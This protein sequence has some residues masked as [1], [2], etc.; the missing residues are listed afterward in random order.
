MDRGSTVADPNKI[1]AQGDE[2]SLGARQLNMWTRGAQ[3]ALQAF[4]GGGSDPLASAPLFTPMRIRNFTEYQI[5]R[6]GVVSYKTPTV[7]PED[8]EHR[9]IHQLTID[10]ILPEDPL[11]R[12]A[13]CLEPI[14]EQGI[15]LAAIFGVVPCWITGTG[16]K[17]E[18]IGGDFQ[19]L[20]AGDSGHPLLWQEDGYGERFALILLGGGSSSSSACGTPRYSLILWYCYGG[21]LKLSLIGVFEPIEISWNSTAE[22]AEDVINAAIGGGATVT[23]GPLPLA[24]LLIEL[25]VHQRLIVIPT[26]ADELTGTDWTPDPTFTLIACGWVI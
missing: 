6:L 14:A 12:F 22:E 21:V 20:Q 16:E 23:G 3:L 4:G 18:A 24:N 25:P 2:L 11:D 17:A 13:I 26:S 7:L 19:T 9:F 10:A 5:P 15:G 1:W 8:D